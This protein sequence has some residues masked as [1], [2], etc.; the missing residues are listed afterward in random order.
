MET[1]G[2]ELKV[3]LRWPQLIGWSEIKWQYKQL[4]AAWFRVL[5]L[6]RPLYLEFQ[7]GPIQEV[8]FQPLHPP[9]VPLKSLTR[10][11]QRI[12][13]QRRRFPRPFP[14]LPAN[15]VDLIVRVYRP[16]HYFPKVLSHH[17][18]SENVLLQHPANRA[19][20]SVSPQQNHLRARL[21]LRLVGAFLHL[22]PD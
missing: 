4:M 1:Q 16:I 15:Q 22:Y 12:P 10:P 18:H 20:Q 5:R 11:G 13:A 2:K 9:L 21:H 3:I 17:F 19:H 14:L 7:L 6:D 8:H